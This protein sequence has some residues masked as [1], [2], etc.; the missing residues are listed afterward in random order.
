MT[1]LSVGGRGQ[2]WV[3]P[4]ASSR[5][6]SFSVEGRGSRALL[7]SSWH[8]HRWCGQSVFTVDS[9]TVDSRVAW[10][11]FWLWDEFSSGWGRGGRLMC[12]IKIPQQ[13]FAQKLQGEAYVQRRRICGTLW[14]YMDTVNPCNGWKVE[15]VQQLWGKPAHNPSLPLFQNLS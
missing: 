5:L 1:S 13:E 10:I 8:V 7:R 2:A 3:A 4:D 6:T 12:G 14:Y 11:I 15:I 9:L